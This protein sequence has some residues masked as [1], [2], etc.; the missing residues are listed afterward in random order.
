MQAMTAF[1]ASLTANLEDSPGHD[2]PS[3]HTVGGVMQHLLETD[4][5]AIVVDQT[6][7]ELEAVGLGCVRASVPGLIPMH[8][9]ACLERPNASGERFGLPHPFS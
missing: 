3:L 5:G 6:P 9:G 4:L 8:C 1:S 7:P 2:A